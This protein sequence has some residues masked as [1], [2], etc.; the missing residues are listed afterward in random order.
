MERLDTHS[1]FDAFGDYFERFK[2][3]AMTK[4]DDEHVSHVI[5]PDMVFLTDSLISDEIPCKSEENML[6]EPRHDRKP[7]VV[8]INADFSSD[9][10]PCNDIL[11]KF[12]IVVPVHNR[13][14]DCIQS[15]EPSEPVPISV[16]N[17]DSNEHILDNTEFYPMQC[18]TEKG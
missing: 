17:S 7:D 1:D 10:L 15:Q 8:L 12:E 14:G 18:R 3:W 5:V 11:N 6:N 9:P 13:H 16:I 2:I 4:E